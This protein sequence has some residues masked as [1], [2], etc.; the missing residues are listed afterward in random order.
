MKY[1]VITTT[2]GTLKDARKIMKE[3]LEK[4]LIACCQI[5]S[6]DSSY[7]WN[8][9]IENE[10]EYLLIMKTKASLYNEVEQEIL[11]NHPYEV[12]EIT[13]TE[14]TDGYFEYLNWIKD[15]TKN[16]KSEI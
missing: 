7:W 14:I 5:Q 9:R 8:Q 12:P 6:I 16:P 2:V 11:E 4:R 15:E 3:L 13:M 10:K 1:C